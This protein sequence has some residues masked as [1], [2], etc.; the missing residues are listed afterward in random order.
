MESNFR[1]KHRKEH[2]ENADK[3][4]RLIFNFRDIN[5]T[6]RALYEGRGSQKRILMIL[7]DVGTIT[8][9]G[10]TEWLGIQPGSASAVLAK[11]EKSGLIARTENPDDRRTT[12]ITLTE[13][14]KEMAE[15]AAE[16]RK[17]RHEQMFINLTEG[18]KDTLLALLEKLNADWKE[19]YQNAAE[20]SCGSHD[21]CGH[22]NRGHGHHHK[23]KGR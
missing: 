22:G 12:D 2:Y 7:L 11:L 16:Q 13:Q 3:N 15:E 21:Q 18:E 9:R 4:D 10:L 20:H 23:E 5:H 17:L 6:M 14:G 1:E 19:R 8:Q